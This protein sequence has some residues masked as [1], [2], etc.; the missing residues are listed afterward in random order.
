L[1]AAALGWFGLC[2]L[3][4]IKVAGMPI[5]STSDAATAS[6]NAGR[7]LSGAGGRIVSG[8]LAPSKRRIAASM[9]ASRATGRGGGG[10]GRDA[11]SGSGGI[12][13]NS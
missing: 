4:P 10:S 3:M 12:Y 13:S 6:W 7:R 5:I 2:S 11:D 8:C 9:A 1:G